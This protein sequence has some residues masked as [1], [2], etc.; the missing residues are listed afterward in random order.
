M[1]KFGVHLVDKPSDM[2]G[3]VDAMLV[4][5]RANGAHGRPDIREHPAF[6][7]AYATLRSDAPAV[8]ALHADP[9]GMR[10][11]S[12]PPWT[13]PAAATSALTGVRPN[14]PATRAP[15]MTVT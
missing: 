4:E 5:A 14:P 3:K 15:S 11:W 10:Y 8:H 6:A 9:E 1:K 12:T 13:D 2:I 7:A